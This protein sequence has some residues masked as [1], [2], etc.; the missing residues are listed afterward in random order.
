[1]FFFATVSDNGSGVSMFIA[2]GINLRY[3]L[4]REIKHD[5]G[6]KFG[7]STLSTLKNFN[8]NVE[9]L[10]I[11]RFAGKRFQLSQILGIQRFNNKHKLLNGRQ[12][13]NDLK[14]CNTCKNF[15]IT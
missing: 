14:S 10:D 8:H 4:F 13:I 1:M 12:D 2:N 9:L 3:Q 6:S 15:L 11:K 5:N 7:L